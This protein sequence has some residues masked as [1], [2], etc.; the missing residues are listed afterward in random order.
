MCDLPVEEC[1]ILLLNQSSKVIDRLKVSI[2]GLASTQVDIRCIL[3]EALLKRAVSVILCHNHPSGNV[4]P[5]RD[6]DRLTEAL[7]RAGEVMNIR[8]LDH[9]IIT[10]GTYY[11]YSDEGRI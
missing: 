10:D 9:I 8:L 6:D 3:R 1:W 5:S 7:R 2:G 11:S 4:S